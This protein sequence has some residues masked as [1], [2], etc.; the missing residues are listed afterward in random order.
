M[1][2]SRFIGTCSAIVMS[3]WTFSSSLQ[4]EDA[5][6][7]NRIADVINQWRPD[8]HVYVKGDIGVDADRLA[9]LEE[10]LD[11]NGDNWTVVLMEEAEQ[12]DFHA[13]DGRDYVG[14][15]AVEYALGYGLSN[16]TG[17]GDLENE[18][19][20]ESDGAV[21]ALFLKER[22]F[23]YFGSDAQDR[24]GL[25]ES[26]WIGELDQPAFR[27]MRS[28]G[29]ILDAVKDT[30]SNINSRLE[31]AIQAEADA[32][33]REA[34]E[35]Q[36]IMEELK[37]EIE[38]VR[39]SISEAEGER[40]K[41]RAQFPQAEGELAKPPI[42]AW[43]KQ[44]A[45][46]EGEIAPERIRDLLQRVATTRDDVARLLNAYAAVG[47]VGLRK[48]ALEA[49]RKGLAEGEITASP[50]DLA[51]IDQDLDAA[52]Q[53]VA[54]GNPDFP[55]SFSEVEN[56]LQRAEAEVAAEAERRRLAKARADLVRKTAIVATAI[57][58]LVLLGFLFVLNRR[59]KK[60]RDKS[61]QE[62][63]ERQE[64]VR[65]EMD[66]VMELFARS[67]EI[68]GDRT[69]LAARGYEGETKALSEATLQYVDDLFVMSN[70][71]KRV[72]QEAKELIYPDS[73]LEWIANLFSSARYE[74]GINQVTGKP[75]KFSRDKGLPLVL[76][77]LPGIQPGEPTDPP[78]Q[79]TAK[80]GMT[81]EKEAEDIS[82]TFEDVFRAFNERY[83]DAANGLKTLE[84]S[85][86][87]VQTQLKVLE[88]EI[89]KAHELDKQ[90]MIKAEADGY[91]AMPNLLERLLR[92][93]E[94]DYRQADDLSGFDPVRAVRVPLANG[95][96]KLL[97][98]RMLLET[99]Q[100]ARANLF[101]ILQRHADELKGLAYNSDWIDAR[102]DKLTH[103]ANELVG[104]C[105]EKSVAS[106]IKEFE[107][108][109]EELKVQAEQAVELGQRIKSDDE[110]QLAALAEK[111]A[112]ARMDLARQLNL[113][114]A[115]LLRELDLE[116]DDYL[117]RAQ[118]NLKAARSMLV[119]G[120]TE[121]ALAALE[122]MEKEASQV[123]A[124]L[125][126]SRE[127][128]AQ[129]Q[130][131]HEQLRHR[132]QE[133]QDE[134]RRVHMSLDSASQEFV[135][136]ALLLEPL[137]QEDSASHPPAAQIVA[138]AERV[139]LESQRSLELASAQ[140]A[141]GRVLQASRLL[142]ESELSLSRVKAQLTRVENHLQHLRAQAA[143]NTAAV[144][145]FV[146]E[147]PQVRASTQHAWVTQRTM[148]F[149]DSL[150]QQLARLRGD[151]DP[152]S[153][154]RNPAETA[155]GIS[156]LKGQWEKIAGMISADKDAFAEASRAVA[157]AE[158]Q[159]EVARSLVSQASA[160]RVADSTKITEMIRRTA[161][162]GNSLP[163]LQQALRTPHEDWQA[164]DDAAAKV[165]ADLSIATEVLRGEIVAAERSVQAFQQASQV[166]YKAAQWS[167]PGGIR[168]GGSPGVGE[169]ERA[170]AALQAGD[171][172][173][174]LQASL[175]ATAAATAAM[176]QAEREVARRRME[177]ARAAEAARR[178]REAA[179][180]PR[181]RTFGG[182]FPTFPS[183]PSSSGQSSGPSWS[184]SG[185]SSSSRGSGGGG[186]GGSGFQR[187]G[188]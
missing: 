130:T 96:R 113:E 40:E 93:L 45:A 161:T 180:R 117:E 32:A 186:G 85:L 2:S 73:P 146:Q 116:P 91:F 121:P 68:L 137:G 46:I 58:T 108:S 179:S 17:F 150:G 62:F 135:H 106:Q 151:I 43:Q 44:L 84:V 26:N 145:R 142:H 38:A 185:G 107:S 132:A 144:E 28:G 123:E 9:V 31:Q 139:L 134:A 181:T 29:R 149:T 111:I 25:G 39:Q 14:M 167:G 1:H 49:R 55:R 8:Q 90:L 88:S 12:E 7:I 115:R 164:I 118:S 81:P 18:R 4:G 143:E 13:P 15:D 98:L 79:T 47:A 53:A 175:T 54:A 16:R 48:E 100:A 59:R 163:R 37:H 103:Q 128:V 33:E 50:D 72:M 21:F 41:Y 148:D 56:S 122:S 184:S 127:S 104:E 19:T 152:Q 101:P 67:G 166:V 97:E 160:D 76:R 82:L 105:S 124:I 154:T 129:H 87:E 95:N 57:T 27:A 74:R 126:D 110:P 34:R 42:E 36:R 131:R 174:G 168:V 51:D 30:V 5:V 188:W 10:W 157:G 172:A 70:E 141:E 75:L 109:L 162:L 64:F 178:A 78:P 176:E 63:R 147:Q 92:S 156:A 22:K 23:S 65:N 171:Y 11:E 52:L 71:V 61:I 35:R 120:R 183:F 136:A 94:S 20:G 86:A 165:Q 112:E 177:E 173:V 66:R 155:K 60:V 140:Y 159:Y 89:E 182:G 80:A 6:R 187:S 99:I 170:R 169:L 153:G 77:K 69:R 158:R 133:L 114:P 119:Q 102:L 83:Q 3:L 138:E 125:V 24:R